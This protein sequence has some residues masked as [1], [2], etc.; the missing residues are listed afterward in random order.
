MVQWIWGSCERINRAWCN[1]DWR[2]K[3]PNATI[4]YLPKISSDHHPLLI[5]C[6]SE[7]A[8]IRHEKKFRVEISW[9]DRWDFGD[10][11][12][13][14]WKD[15][16]E[17]LSQTLI[18]FSQQARWWEKE[19]F[20]SVPKCKRRCLVRLLGIQKAHSYRQEYMRTLEESL[21]NE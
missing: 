7:S 18:Y 6:D 9:F 1:V 10:L 14:V 17:N 13:K 16:G 8:R 11:V 3:A 15:R 5:Q 12:A 2:L 19:N 4:W 20:G 21:T